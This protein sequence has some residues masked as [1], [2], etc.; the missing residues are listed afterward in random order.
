MVE[1]LPDLA[2]NVLRSVTDDKC[3]MSENAVVL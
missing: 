2:G 3:G 1:C